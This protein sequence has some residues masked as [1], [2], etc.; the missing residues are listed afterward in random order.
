MAIFG[1]KK[2][3]DELRTLMTEKEGKLKKSIS[4]LEAEKE[5]RERRILTRSIWRCW[6][7]S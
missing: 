2:E 4:E 5:Q 3:V 6:T 7:S 1:S